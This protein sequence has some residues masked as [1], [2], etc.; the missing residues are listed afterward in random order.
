MKK[1][2]VVGIDDYHSAP[3]Q[4]CVNDASSVAQLLE[5]NGD[6]SPNFS[7]RLLTSDKLEV[8]A[9][10]LLQAITEL[11]S[12][13]ADTAL[14]FFAGHG[15]I[16][17]ETNAGYIVSQDGR[18]PS[19]G[20]TLSDILHLANQAYPRVKSSVIIL[21]SCQSGYAGEIQGLGS[22]ANQPS[23]IGNGVTILTAS[24]REG[25]AAEEDGHGLFTSI[26]LDGLSGSSADVIGRITPASV[27]SHI[28][29]TLG[30]WKQ[31]PVYKANV[32]TFV[33]LRNVAPKI[34]HEV[35][36]RLPE[37]FPDPAHVFQLD[38]SYEPDRENVPERVKHIPVDEDHK[39]IFKELQLCNRHGLIV[40]VD[41]EHMYYAAIDSKGCRLSALGAHYRKLAI[42]GRI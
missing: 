7:V 24:H 14:L 8:N 21:D 32:Q 15:I 20:V 35:L 9:Q 18:K 17:P 29:Q 34:P 10:V 5:R 26:L 38:P 13:D 36:R 3:L 2:L 27:Y 23:V 42:L 19:W 16:N 1:A 4:G 37:Y 41:A 28:D 25:T 6:G 30:P 22:A 11:F 33:T 39:R 31:R 12:G 40:P